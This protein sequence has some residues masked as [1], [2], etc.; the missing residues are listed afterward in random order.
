MI[1]YFCGKISKIDSDFFAR[2]AMKSNSKV[3][4]IIMKHNLGQDLTHA[5]LWAAFEENF[6]TML[7][8]Y[9]A[10]K[11]SIKLDILDGLIVKQKFEKLLQIFERT[12]VRAQKKIY[13]WVIPL[14]YDINRESG[15]RL[16]QKNYEKYLKF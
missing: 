6:D 3:L 1:D 15:K 7:C 8:I 5:F 13:F 4:K 11:G 16:R 14:I 10:A 12:K 2:I 9:E